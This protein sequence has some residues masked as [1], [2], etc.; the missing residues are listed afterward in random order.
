M[1]TPLQTGIH[2]YPH[3]ALW[4]VAA[5]GLLLLW[6]LHATRPK[7]VAP[8]FVVNGDH[9]TQVAH[10]YWLNQQTHAEA[11]AS[12][13]TSSTIRQQ[14][15]ARL[16][17]KHRAPAAKSAPHEL[18]RPKLGVDAETTT[19]GSAAPARPAGSPLGTVL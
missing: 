9:G 8:S 6:L 1:F 19:L 5:H 2:R 12:P 15:N 18:P 17:W 4:S 16:T 11:H 7:V 3:A 10:L 14:L 13:G